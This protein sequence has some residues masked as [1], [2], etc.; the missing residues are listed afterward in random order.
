MPRPKLLSIDAFAKTVEDAR[1]RTTSGGIITLICVILVLVL[2]NNEYA[3]YTTVITRPDLVVD[4]DINRKLKINLDISFPNIPCDL[5]SLDITD[6]TGDSSLDLL[7]QGFQ[8]FR[9]TKDGEGNIKDEI[10]DSDSNF[11]NVHLDVD[12]LAKGGQQPCGSCHGA[13]PQ[14]NNE[15]CCNSCEVVKAAY[16][17][18][19]WA[20][21]DGENIE[22]CEKEG[23]VQRLKDRINGNEGCRVKGSTEI[24]RVSGV[25]DFGPGTSFYSQRRHVHDMSLYDKYPDKFNFDHFVHH[26]SFGDEEQAHHFVDESTHPL[27]DVEFIVGE[28]HR[29]AAYY[30]KVISTRKEFIDP[31]EPAV[32]TN[33]FSAVTHSRPIRGGRDQDHQ[34]TMHALGGTPGVF[35][36]F[37]ISPL[38]IINREQYA[39]T[40]SGFVLGVI[41]SIAGVLI[42]GSLVDRSVFAA[43]KAIRGKKNL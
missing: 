43:E 14:D 27:D 20:F 37:D 4:R 18:K 32:E 22:Q 17:L 39:K 6:Q 11:V 29:M 2:I 25:M 5:L 13:L 34:H 42:V 26:L 12:E 7:Q 16:A 1:I 38:K 30:L 35:F 10:K 9:L 33:Q 8:K 24:R 40:W 23:Y 36:N 3:D 31:E 28:K 15:Y 41:S 21:Y 19:Q